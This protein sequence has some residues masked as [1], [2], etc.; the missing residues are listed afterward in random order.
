[1]VCIGHR[2]RFDAVSIQHGENLSPIHSDVSKPRDGMKNEQLR[3]AY[4]NLELWFKMENFVVTEV[5]FEPRNGPSS[6]DFDATLSPSATVPSSRFFG[7][8]TLA[9]IQHSFRETP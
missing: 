6:T 3:V 1:M 9:V 2:I 5:S 4:T 8:I 7:R